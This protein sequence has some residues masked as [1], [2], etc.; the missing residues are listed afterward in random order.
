MD[1]K[2]SVAFIAA[3]H[4][5][6]KTYRIFSLSSRWRSRVLRMRKKK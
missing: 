1:K 6:M 2:P 3:F 5:K 4:I